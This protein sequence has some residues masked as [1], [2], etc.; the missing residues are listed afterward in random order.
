MDANAF[1]HIYIDI[2]INIDKDISICKDRN[3]DFNKAHLVVLM[4]LGHRY[5][6]RC[7]KHISTTKC[8]LLKS[9]FLSLLMEMSLSMLMPMSMSMYMGK[10]AFA[11]IC[12]TMH[13][14]PA[15]FL[16]GI[17]TSCGDCR[18]Y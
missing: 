11:S 16:Q 1:L 13:R 9:M 18:N 2:H 4:G 15:S 10:I 7:P 6:T 3:I 14:I 8:A 17:H 5:Q 12:I